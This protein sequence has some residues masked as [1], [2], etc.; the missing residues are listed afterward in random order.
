MELK[1]RDA[2]DTYKPTILAINQ[3]LESKKNL[4]DTRSHN[5]EDLLLEHNTQKMSVFIAKNAVEQLK[6]HLRKDSYNETGGVLVGQAYFCPETEAN[7]T[8]IIGSIAA[9]YTVG[10]QV[11]FKFTT[12]C[13]QNI[14][15]IQKRDFPETA[16]VGW[17]HSHPG[18][19]IFLSTTD[20]NTQRLSFKQLWHIAIVYD[21]IQSQIGFFYSAKGKKIDAIYLSNSYPDSQLNVVEPDIQWDKLDIGTKEDLKNLEEAEIKGNR[22]YKRKE[23]SEL[24]NNQQSAENSKGEELGEKAANIQK[25]KEFLFALDTIYDGFSKLFKVIFG[26][27][28]G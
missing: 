21:P 1:W 10:N 13:W 4:I 12:E 9:L 7:Y 27:F 17:Y 25:Q 26:S 19:G 8:E 14:F 3:F 2:E 15:Q 24:G 6:K 5:I 23:P 16:I 11:H 18:H 22:E 28:K 20:L